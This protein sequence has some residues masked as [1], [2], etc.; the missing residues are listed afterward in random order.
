MAV[1]HRQLCANGSHSVEVLT[2]HRA[3]NSLGS[4]VSG[5]LWLLLW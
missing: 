4:V 1:L 3:N 5:A 2:L